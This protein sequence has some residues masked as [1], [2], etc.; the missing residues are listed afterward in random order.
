MAKPTMTNEELQLKQ[1]ARRRLIGAVT[2][3]TGL[4]VF[5]PMV[6]DNEPKPVAEDIAINIPSQDGSAVKGGAVA[7]AKSP[8]AENAAPKNSVA[9][10]AQPSAAVTKTEPPPAKPAAPP[11][12]PLT[13]SASGQTSKPAQ[14]SPPEQTKAEPP[15]PALSKPT[16][17]VAA[18][19]FV[20]RLGAFSKPENAKQ[21]KT[22]VTMM[23]I[24]NYAET[25][26]TDAGEK[27]LVRAG[28]FATRREA[29]IVRDRL[30]AVDVDGDVVSK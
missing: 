29:E 27:T 28:P 30:K 12:Q 11:I 18:Q 2:L 25:A 24:R 19:G 8:A 16:E 14:P 20:V 6:L 7:P 9:P 1:R 15:K 17:A 22:K 10:H 21:L 26:K 23:G 13:V 5:L 3:V 4:V